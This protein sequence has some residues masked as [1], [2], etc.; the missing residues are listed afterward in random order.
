MI[1]FWYDLASTYS[2]ITAQRIEGVAAAA[3]LEVRWRPFLLGPI[4][5]GQGWGTSPFNLYPAKGRYMWRDM[6]RL[7]AAAGLPL[8]RPAPFPANSLLPARVAVQGE[9][10]G[11]IGAFTKAV[12][13]AEFCEGAN[14]SEADVLRGILTDLD[15]DAGPI[16]EAARSEPVKQRLKMQT[17]AAQRLGMFGA[18]TFV[19]DGELFWGNDRLEEA[20]RWADRPW[21]R[22]P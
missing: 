18:P 22:E 5:A 8:K 17:D 6:E 12:F 16:L 4:F 21:V 13:Q 9:A 1:E 15:L 11:W 7:S 3:G 14:I 19:V 10:A 2:H 20:V